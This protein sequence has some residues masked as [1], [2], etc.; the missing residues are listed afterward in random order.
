MPDGWERLARD[1]ALFHIDPTASGA[2]LDEFVASGAALVDWVLA[3]AGELPGHDRALE[4]G[5]GVGRNLVHLAAHFAAVDGVDVSP[6]MLRLAA[7]HGLP[8]N[9]SLH[10]TSGRDLAPFPGG[11]F[12]LV[13]S[14]LVFQHVVEPDVLRAYLAETARV[15]RP[16]GVAVVQFDT[17][18]LGLPARALRRLPDPLLPRSR[19]RHMRRTPREAAWVREQARAAGLR[20]DA[21]QGAGGPEHWLR[22]VR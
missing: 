3:W 18:R 20:L 13:Y 22:L 4:I 2:R 7:E 17:R 19:R 21:E 1:D 5:C 12:D 9:V 16:G 15:L 10:E 8:A 14:H 6:T 11:R